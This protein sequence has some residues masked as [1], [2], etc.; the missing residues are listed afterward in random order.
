MDFMMKW[1]FYTV[2]VVEVLGFAGK[3]RTKRLLYNN[4]QFYLQSENVGL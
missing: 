1:L 2:L 4:K 3:I